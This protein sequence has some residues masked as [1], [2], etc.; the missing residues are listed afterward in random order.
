MGHVNNAVYL[1]YVESARVAFLEHL[2]AARTLEELA[3]I[4]A[5]VEIDF[6]APVRFGDEVEVTVRATRFG[7]KS[8]D[9]EHEL[10]V[11]E[12]VVA[13][14]KTVLVTYDYEQRRPVAIPGEWRDKLA[15]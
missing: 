15:A 3:I 2:G 5:R 6:R 13:E 12:T 11:G 14:V 9:L 4:V 10:R 8:F 1:T 7:E